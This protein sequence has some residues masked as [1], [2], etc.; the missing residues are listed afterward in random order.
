MA[1]PKKEVCLRGHPRRGGNLMP[2]GNCKAC[3]KLRREQHRDKLVAYNKAYYRE[4]KE[5][6][7][8]K[9]REKYITDS[10]FKKRVIDRTSRR[11]L[12]L[13][14]WSPELIAEYRAKQDDKCAIC[15]EKFIKTPHGDH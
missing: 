13:R 8:A 5:E 6:E 4:H 10:D 3:K 11:Q 1:P 2:D 9:V 7:C 15:Q 14:G 12:K